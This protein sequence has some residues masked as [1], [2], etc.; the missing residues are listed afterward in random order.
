MQNYKN[1]TRIKPFLAVIGVLLLMDSCKTPQL[2]IYN[3]HHRPGFYV[4]FQVGFKDNQSIEKSKDTDNKPE[5][6]KLLSS[7]KKPYQNNFAK[8]SSPV[9]RA[10]VIEKSFPDLNRPTPVNETIPPQSH[11]E[12]LPLNLVND[13]VRDNLSKKDPRN[14]EKVTPKESKIAFGSGLAALTSA[15][16]G[17]L[18]GSP[19]FLLA[20]LILGIVAVG[21]GL[22]ANDK[23]GTH[24]ELKGKT[25]VNIGLI[26]ALVPIGLG[27]IA[28]FIY[29][30][31]VLFVYFWLAIIFSNN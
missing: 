9:S 5:K 16:L 4:D 29:L 24:S 23:I 21:T 31:A 10:P 25:L 19:A 26:S 8:V 13:I 6:A 20:Y 17:I 1:I 18:L 3:R 2:E 22:K 7:V 11:S 28:A 27:I 12:K 15:G 14:G 30:F